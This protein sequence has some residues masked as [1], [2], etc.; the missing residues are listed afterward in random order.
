MIIRR[1]RNI[2]SQKKVVTEGPEILWPEWQ[3]R[4][5]TAQ[6]PWLPARLQVKHW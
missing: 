5:Q 4:A 2:Q 3:V 1:E 6:H